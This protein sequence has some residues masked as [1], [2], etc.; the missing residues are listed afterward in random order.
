MRM[1]KDAS[2][3]S[4]SSLYLVIFDYLHSFTPV[5]T[6]KI[7]PISVDLYFEGTPPARDESFK[8]SFVQIGEL[9]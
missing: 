1:L 9:V 2:F 3:V 8:P 7:R 4:I 6:L 5:L